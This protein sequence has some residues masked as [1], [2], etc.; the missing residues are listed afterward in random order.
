M[1]RQRDRSEN[2]RTNILDAAL[3][4][5]LERGYAATSA[6]RIVKSAQVSRGAMLHHFPNRA[7]LMAALL[8]HV[9][10]TREQTF[11]RALRESEADPLSRIFD[12]F[13]EAVGQNEAFFPGWS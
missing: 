12:A 11:H 13:W 6:I 4:V 3:H 10:Q 7:A 9:L 5:L 1:S 8:R 2:T